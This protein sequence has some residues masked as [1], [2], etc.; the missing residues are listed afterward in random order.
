MTNTETKL[1]V[2]FWV[3]AALALVWNAL[4]VMA[5]LNDNG[6]SDGAPAWEIGAFAIAVFGGVLGS[7]L[8]LLRKNIATAVFAL[9]LL[10]V[11]VQQYYFYAVA[12]IQG[13]VGLMSML[14]VGG[15]VFLLWFSRFCANKA[16]LG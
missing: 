15:A 5:Y 8:L 4:G 1:P 9:S 10:G 13:G 12:D 3:I 2:W 14:I 16:W 11:L 7:I 6:S